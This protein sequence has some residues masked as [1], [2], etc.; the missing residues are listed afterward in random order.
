[1]RQTLAAVAG[2]DDEVF[3]PDARSLVRQIDPGL[4]GDDISGHEHIRRL[5]AQRGRLMDLES[6]SVSHPVTVGPAEACLLDP[7]TRGGVRVAPV[8]SGRDR[9]ETG[10]L[11]VEAECVELLQPLGH[12]ADRKGAGAIRAVAVDDAPGIDEYE[13]ACLDRASP[14]TA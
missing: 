5:G 3:D 7:R 10:E 9:G 1:M 6:H 4:D 8:D 2:H 12:L 11:G 14:G 13:N